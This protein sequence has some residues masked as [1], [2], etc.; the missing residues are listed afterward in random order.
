MWSPR[1]FQLA[2]CCDLLHGLGLEAL[3]GQKV[4][5]VVDASGQ[6][7]LDWHLQVRNVSWASAR[8]VVTSHHR[9]CPPPVGWKFG[10]GIFNGSELVDVLSVGRP[11][12]RLIDASRVWRSTAL[13]PAIT[14][15]QFSPKVISRLQLAAL[16]VE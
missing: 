3:S 6:L 8:D 11:V 1:E 15:S 9:H 13:S 7:L 16:P 5:R 12:G 2:T 10:A 4:R 14:L